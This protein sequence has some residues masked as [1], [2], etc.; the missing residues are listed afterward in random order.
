MS[1]DRCEG[2]QK[3]DYHIAKKIADSMS[4]RDR[5]SI[6]YK[7]RLCGQYHVAGAL[8]GSLKQLKRFKRR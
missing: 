4:R 3:H 7:C 8:T 5:K 6:P 1:D 2:K